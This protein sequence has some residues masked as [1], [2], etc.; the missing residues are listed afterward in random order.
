MQTEISM[1]KVKQ[2]VLDM[3]MA[4]LHIELKKQILDENKISF[5]R[6]DIQKLQKYIINNDWKNRK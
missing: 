1:L 6:K 2:V 5:L 4:R 3:Q